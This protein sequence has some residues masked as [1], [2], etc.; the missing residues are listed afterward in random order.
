MSLSSLFLTRCSS[1]S[2]N[3]SLS[4]LSFPPPLFAHVHTHATLTLARVGAISSC[5]SAPRNEDSQ[6]ESV[7]QMVGE[8]VNNLFVK[9]VC[10]NVFAAHLLSLTIEGTKTNVTRSFVLFGGEL[11]ARLRGSGR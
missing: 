3:F 8:A 6:L 11:D 10:L 7:R 5:D 9:Q 2:G 1:F 4:R